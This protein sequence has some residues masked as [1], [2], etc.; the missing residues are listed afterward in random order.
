MINTI[1]LESLRARIVWRCGQRVH[2]SFPTLPRAFEAISR[3]T[4]AGRPAQYDAFS[5]DRHWI[6]FDCQQVMH[7]ALV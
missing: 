4:D 7:F 6:S 5:G 1:P 3:L 2:V